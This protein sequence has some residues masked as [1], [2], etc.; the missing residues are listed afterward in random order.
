MSRRVE[1]RRLRLLVPVLVLGLCAFCQSQPPEPQKH[2]S[3]K[4]GDSTRG[5]TGTTA[6]G[7]A[8]ETATISHGSPTTPPENWAREGFGPPTWSNWALV[9]AAIVAAAV[10][11]RTLRAIKNQADTMAQQAGLMERQSVA[12]EK[13]I[14]I[15]RFSANAAKDSAD[16]ARLASQTLIDSERAWVVIDKVWPPSLAPQVTAAAGAGFNQF[17]FDIKNVGRTVARLGNF[18]STWRVLPRSEDLPA[19]PD[20]GPPEALP[21]ILAPIHGKVMAPGETVGKLLIGIY[22][23]FD[24]DKIAKIRNGLLTLWVYGRIKYFDVA[25]Q[26]RRVH[27]CYRYLP[28]D[29]ENGTERYVV[30]G[31]IEYNIHS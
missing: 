14:E 28:R 17:L 18:R 19:T 20:F 11:L 30:G 9:I 24:D 10:A 16:V 2:E 12:M 23:S 13:Q 25:G 21:S 1:K 6:I 15:A 27:F 22:E 4:N 7:S 8:A 5:G 3:K 29:P 31:P 26:Q